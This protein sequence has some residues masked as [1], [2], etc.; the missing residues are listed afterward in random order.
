MPKEIIVVNTAAN[1]EN[2]RKTIVWWKIG[3]YFI[4]QDNIR[5]LSRKGMGKGTMIRMYHGEDVRVDVDYDKL[6]LMLP[7]KNKI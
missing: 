5:A 7:A 1:A 4:N 6:I 3:K 2:N